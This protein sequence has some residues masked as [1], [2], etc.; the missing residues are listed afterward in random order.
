MFK[1]I[2]N[3]FYQILNLNL[4]MLKINRWSDPRAD[5]AKRRARVLI[6]PGYLHPG[7]LSISRA[8][9]SRASLTNGV[10]W[11]VILTDLKNMADCL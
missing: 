11:V 1:N 2:A 9:I 10:E 5:G 3:F 6:P 7:K 8:Q 4:G